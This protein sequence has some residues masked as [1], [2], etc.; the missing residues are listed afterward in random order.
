MKI[1]G[2]IPHERPMCTGEDNIRMDVT[3]RIRG[4]ESCEHCNEPSVCDD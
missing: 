4:T 2:A 3:N 1:P